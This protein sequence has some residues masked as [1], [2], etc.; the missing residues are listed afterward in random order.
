MQELFEAF[1][2]M[3]RGYDMLQVYAKSVGCKIYNASSKTFVD[4]FE[5]VKPEQIISVTDNKLE[6]LI[7]NVK[8]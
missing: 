6:N 3:F 5:R 2:T 1:A 7:D 4:A 8:K